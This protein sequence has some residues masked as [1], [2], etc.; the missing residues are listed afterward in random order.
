[1]SQ[2]QQLYLLQQIDT[3]IREKKQRLGEVLRAQKETEE[4]LVARGRLETA[5]TTLQNWRTKRQNLEQELQTLKN[6][7]KSAEQRLYSGNVKNPKELTDLQNSIE[8]LGRQ[9]AA[10]EDEILETM[11]SIEDTETEKAAAERTHQII[12]GE[13]E[14]SQGSLKNE[15]NELALRVHELIGQRKARLTT[16]TTESLAEYDAISRKA[17]GIAVVK[18]KNSLCTGCRLNV[19]AQKEKDAREGK[20]VYCANCGRILAID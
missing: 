20:K 13:W 17:K 5:V 7:A 14:Q 11:I 3:E 10:M 1:M 18:I 4:L 2:V 19:S 6:K 15:Q 8:S 12:Q 9:R 16:I